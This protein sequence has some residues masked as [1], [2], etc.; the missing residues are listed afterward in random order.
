MVE[1][2]GWFLRSVLLRFQDLILIPIWLVLLLLDVIFKTEWAERVRQKISFAEKSKE[3]LYVNIQ[4]FRRSVLIQGLTMEE[5]EHEIKQAAETMDELDITEYTLKPYGPALLLELPNVSLCGFGLLVQWLDDKTSLPVYGFGKGP[6]FGFVFYQ[7]DE[8]NDL[9]GITSDGQKFSLNL[10][11]DLNKV[12]ALTLNPKLELRE[13]F[14]YWSAD[15]TN[16]L[17]T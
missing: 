1:T 3:K 8:V 4:N 11:E 16:T 13:D 10:T 5:A 2:P 12:S 6:Q 14:S 9:H 17:A 15:S 7:S